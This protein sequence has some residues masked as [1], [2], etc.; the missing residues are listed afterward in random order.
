MKR[1]IS[2]LKNKFQTGAK[3][4]QEDF[5]DI[6]D[7]FVH[8]DNQQAVDAQVV[9]QLI[10]AY[11]QSLTAR[12]VNGSVDTLGDVFAL[13]AGVDDN[14]SL[15]ELFAKI[16][17]SKLPNKPSFAGLTWTE[18]FITTDISTY[19]PLATTGTTGSGPTQ[20]WLVSGVGATNQALIVLDIKTERHWFTAGSGG[21][22]GFY[23]DQIIALKLAVSA[24]AVLS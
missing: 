11:N 17:W 20:R 12:N 10:T 21:E 24:K 23:V 14:M 22:S 19:N 5:G 16:D 13:F 7:S 4:T 1:L 8:L 18:Q 15:K 2:Y 3:P 6:F 9:S